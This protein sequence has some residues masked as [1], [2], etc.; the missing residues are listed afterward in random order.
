MIRKLIPLIIFLVLLIFLGIG[1]RLNPRDIPSPLIGKEVPQFTNP[2][3]SHSSQQFSPDSLKGK[4]WILNVWASWCTSCREEHPLLISFSKEKL[5]PI[6]GLNYKDKDDA[7]KD[8][9]KSIGDPYDLSVIDANGKV[10]IDFGVYGVPETFVIDAKGRII[11]KHTG[12]LT[13]D[14]LSKHIRP[15]LNPARKS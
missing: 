8:W 10:G 2:I 12:P 5:V 3:L 14:A 9:L 11:Y 7:A 4:I 15:L 13:E 1:L 6:I